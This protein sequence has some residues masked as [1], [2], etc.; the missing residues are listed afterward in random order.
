M[1]DSNKQCDWSETGN[2]EYTWNCC[3]VENPCDEKDGDCDSKA[4]CKGELQCGLN[5]CNDVN[6][7]THFPD[8]ADCCYDPNSKKMYTV[9]D[10]QS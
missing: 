5:N 4:E 1:T 2:D 9:F 3:S 10:H 7:A 8:S 6:D